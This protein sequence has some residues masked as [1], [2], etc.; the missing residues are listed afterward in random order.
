ML[1]NISHRESPSGE[2]TLQRIIQH[3]YTGDLN[4][5]PSKTTHNSRGQH[6]SSKVS[7]KQSESQGQTQRKFYVEHIYFSSALNYSGLLKKS[8]HL[9][10][11]CCSVTQLCLTLCDPMD[12]S[13]PGFP[14]LHYLLEFAQTHVLWISDAIQPSHLLSSPS[15]YA[16]NLSQHPGFFY[17][18][19]SS[20]Q[21]A[22]VC[23]RNDQGWFPLGFTDLISLL[24]K[25]LSRSLLQTTV[26]K[27]QHLLP[28][29]LPFP[30]KQQ[31]ELDM[32][33][34]TGSK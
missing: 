13:T 34:Q 10:P 30:W 2:Q 7:S 6:T 9:L 14:V 20:H 22:K 12:Y 18:V 1:Q 17:W 26:G 24:S 31:L 19:G 11:C 5:T 8:P 16:V 4:I 29:K 21:V 32:E 28:T 27:H 15:H 25:G 23:Q 3:C 33:Q